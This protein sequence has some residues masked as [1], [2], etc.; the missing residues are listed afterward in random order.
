MFLFLAKKIFKARVFD[1]HKRFKDE[2][3]E[4]DRDF[5]KISKISSIRFMKMKLG[6][7]KLTI[8]RI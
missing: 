3:I 2:T 4:I 5:V 1:R 6:I 8:H 7:L